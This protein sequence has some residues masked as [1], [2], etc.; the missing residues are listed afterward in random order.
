MTL[1]DHRAV[2]GP[3]FEAQLPKY[4]PRTDR[5]AAASQSSLPG[6][7]SDQITTSA[8]TV[9]PSP[10]PEI[11]RFS[12]DSGGFDTG[13]SQLVLASK[14]HP[15]FS[16]ESLAPPICLVRRAGTIPTSSARVLARWIRSGATWGGS[17]SRRS[18]R[19]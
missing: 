8:T 16:I 13:E 1:G 14:P 19:W 4:A 2:A 5:P 10:S 11:T 3:I 17:S 18:P 12:G 9:S 6:A 15:A 7:L